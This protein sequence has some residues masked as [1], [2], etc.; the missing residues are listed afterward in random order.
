MKKRTRENLIAII[1]HGGAALRKS[2]E[3][4]P[5]APTLSTTE[6]EALAAYIA[7]SPIRP[8]VRKECFMRTGSS[9]LLAILCA[10]IAPAQV[11]SPAEIADPSMRTLQ[12]AHLDDL[13]RNHLG[14]GQT[15]VP[16]SLL[17]QPQTRPQLLHAKWA[18]APP[19]PP[20]PRPHP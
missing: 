6:I 14:A 2:A 5:Y 7:R 9:I 18:I 15:R 4:P 1:A 12:Q 19:A 13:Q 16:L 10:A 17:L 3:M 11:L 8:T 20:P